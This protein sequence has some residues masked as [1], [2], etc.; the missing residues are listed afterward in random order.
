MRLL[1]LC[2][3]CTTVLQAT[4]PHWQTTTPLYGNNMIRFQMPGIPEE[5][6]EKTH[7]Y[8]TLESEGNTYSLFI[9][10][11]QCL[12]EGPKDKLK[13]C[14]LTKL[15]HCIPHENMT[16]ISS[17][18]DVNHQRHFVMA[19]ANKGFLLISVCY[20]HDDVVALV[21]RTT[22]KESVEHQKF[23]ESFTFRE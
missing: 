10:P 17:S 11:R 2:F 12:C 4:N 20:N 1:I 19:D 5:H 8:W 9:K 23:I 7:S 6:V 16:I 14:D 21:T 3:L 13:P 18:E 22:N 15:F